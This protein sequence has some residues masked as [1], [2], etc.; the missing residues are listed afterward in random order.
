M[1]KTRKTNP[2]LSDLATDLRKRSWKNE[3]PIWRDVARRLEGPTKRQAEVNLSR[4]ARVLGEG[5]VALVPGKLLAAGSVTR[6]VRVAAF[7]FSQSARTKV[8]AAGGRCLS[9]AELA[10]EN[11]KGEKVRIV[12]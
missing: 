1:Q 5:E 6:P 3:A 8:E 11:P 2:A 4:V 7:S 9:I 12:G 10:A